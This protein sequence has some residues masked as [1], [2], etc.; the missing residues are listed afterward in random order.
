MSS[1]LLAG[2][3]SVVELSSNR[4]LDMPNGLHLKEEVVAPVESPMYL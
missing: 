2:P 3:L 4:G 1:L